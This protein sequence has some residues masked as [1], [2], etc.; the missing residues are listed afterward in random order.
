MFVQHTVELGAL[1]GS[2]GE[3]LADGTAVVFRRDT[4]EKTSVPL[5]A[6]VDGVQSLTDEIQIEMLDAASARRDS[7]ITDCSTLDEVR[8]AAQAGVARVPWRVVGMSGEQ[9]LA[10]AGVSVRCLQST[11]GGVPDEEDGLAY[12]ARAY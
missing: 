12:V 5:E 2:E 7:V 1:V 9:D 11:D 8:D 4:R 6:V 10:A 3:G